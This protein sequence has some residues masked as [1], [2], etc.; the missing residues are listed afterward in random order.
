M[1][2][3]FVP[4]FYFPT[5]W[6]CVDDN[7]KLLNTMSIILEE[8]ARVKLFS[9]AKECLAFFS[10]YQSV[11]SEYSFLR[12]VK[13][14]EGYGVLEHTPLDFNVKTLVD[15]ANNSRR[16]DDISVLIVDYNMPEMTGYELAKAIKPSIKKILLTGDAHDKIVIDGFNNKLIDRVVQKADVS[17]EETLITYLEELSLQYFQ[18]ISSPI[19]S[20]LEAENKLPLSDPAF[21]SFFNG[22]YSE[23]KIKEYYL[24]DKQGSF[25]CIDEEGN[26]F[27]LV[28]QTNAG[29]NAWVSSYS[30]EN[31]LSTEKMKAINERK[32]IPF[33]GLGV[34]AWHIEPSHW[35]N[36]LHDANSFKGREDYYWA[37][38]KL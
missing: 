21:V 14:D 34:E 1:I 38:V 20:A 27:C 5:T 29:I 4:L 15:I 32:K 31:E 36:L 28:I 3:N 13:D 18:K 12:S 30:I 35:G 6:V 26:K 8:H 10:T 24:I 25:L 22:F 33:F 37:V 2:S 11:L 7:K 17:M 9:S 16:F 19:L 23:Y